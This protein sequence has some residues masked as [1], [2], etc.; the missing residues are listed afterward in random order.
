MCYGSVVCNC[1][2]QAGISNL[3]L[4]QLQDNYPPLVPGKI[5]YIQEYFELL[6]GKKCSL[7]SQTQTKM[8]ITG[9]EYLVVSGATVFDVTTDLDIA[10]SRAREL[11]HSSQGSVYIFRP[12]LEIAPKRDVVETSITLG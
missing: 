11:A 4:S 8:K 9:K 7:L 5:H 6:N 10:K 3:M 12:V 1:H 2:D